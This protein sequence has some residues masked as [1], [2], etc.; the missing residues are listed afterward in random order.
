MER[1]EVFLG[2][3]WLGAVDDDG[4]AMAHAIDGHTDRAIAHHLAGTFAIVEIGVIG[5][6]RNADEVGVE[7]SPAG[8][9]GRSG[10]CRLSHG[11]VRGQKLK[12]LGGHNG[13][14]GKRNGMER[15]S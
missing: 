13:G 12:V 11:L 3:E 6:T 4:G 8:G 1:H 15:G 5:R 7:I 14:I 9:L 10:R 2:E